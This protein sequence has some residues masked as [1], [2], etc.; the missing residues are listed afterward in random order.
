[1][2]NINERNDVFAVA[3]EEM[4]NAMERAK[5]EENEKTLEEVF[6]IIAEMDDETFEK[7]NDAEGLYWFGDSRERKNARARMVYNL[8]KYALTLDDWFR[9]VNW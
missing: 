6:N 3:D 4:E 1:M 8:S 2:L 9:W 7:I 5:E